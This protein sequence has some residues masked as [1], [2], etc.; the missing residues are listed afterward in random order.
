MYD[1]IGFG[2]GMPL[3]LLI[4]VNVNQAIGYC[5]PW[6]YIRDEMTYRK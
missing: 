2:I 5:F 1:G 3:I 4:I 6:C